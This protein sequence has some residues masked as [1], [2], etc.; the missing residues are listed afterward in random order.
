MKFIKYA[1][2]ALGFWIAQNFLEFF[3]MMGLAYLKYDLKIDFSDDNYLF[4]N[5]DNAPWGV[6]NKFIFFTIPYII[7]FALICLFV[8]FRYI[9]ILFKL[10]L[11]NGFLTSVLVLLL[12]ILAQGNLKQ[13]TVLIFSTLVSALLIIGASKLASLII[14]IPEKS[15]N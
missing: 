2:A 6:V 8:K 3:V 12:T 5:L 7:I 1:S 15:S 11:L 13:M 10:A 4:M 14:A 9:N